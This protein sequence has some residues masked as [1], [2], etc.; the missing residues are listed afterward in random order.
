MVIRNIISESRQYYLKSARELRSRLRSLPSGSVKKRKIN[1]RKYYYLQYRRG[2]K[3]VHKYLGKARPLEII[4]GLKE[5][6]RLGKELKKLEKS[7]KLIGRIRR[8]K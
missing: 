3:V 6:G 1:N 8:K 4:R 2:K 5:R 7:L